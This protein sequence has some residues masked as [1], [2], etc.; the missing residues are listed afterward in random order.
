MT[1]W[2]MNQIA[3]LFGT[4]R[5]RSKS[6]HSAIEALECRQLMS[7]VNLLR[8]DIIMTR[9]Y[10]PAGRDHVDTGFLVYRPSKNQSFP[11]TLPRLDTPI[12]IN[13]PT[14]NERVEILNFKLH[15]VPVGFTDPQ[16]HLYF[17]GNVAPDSARPWDVRAGIFDY[18]YNKGTLTT[19]RS[20][21]TSGG[22]PTYSDLAIGPAGQIAT[23][24]YTKDFDPNQF[25]IEPIL[26]STVFVHSPAEMVYQQTIAPVDINAS[27]S[28]LL[29]HPTTSMTYHV[30]NNS[31]DVNGW[32]VA[33]AEN[34]GFFPG[35]GL[36]TTGSSV[37]GPG[38]YHFPGGKRTL[39]YG[40]PKGSIDFQFDP[41]AGSSIIALIGDAGGGTLYTK[42]D[43][44]QERVVVIDPIA[45]TART[46]F[47]GN[48]RY[49]YHSIQMDRAGQIFLEATDNNKDGS[50]VVF[51]LQK[52]PK[53]KS[54]VAVPVFKALAST[55]N[56]SVTDGQF[57][58]VK[59]TGDI[60]GGSAAPTSSEQSSLIS[61]SPEK[62]PRAL[63]RV[64]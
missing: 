43:I 42:K 15:W 61:K 18:D 3:G 26:Q 8:G 25:A 45:K 10:L 5:S 7:N 11:I 4:R 35:Q 51:V 23:T 49:D 64:R 41:T 62:R 52:P 44:V 40:V 46:L 24:H 53:S 38:I 6:P 37:H 14:L 16:P 28:Y 34:D 2:I 33:F 17:T 21:P 22:D 36:V 47:V 56:G 20:E 32:I 55:A 58:V 60:I 12:N 59:P 9:N 31:A 13:V 54:Y 57:V 19:V 29:S 39:I 27:F 1:T 63:R 50:S 30:G 48:S